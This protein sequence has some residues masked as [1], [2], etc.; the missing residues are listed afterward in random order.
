MTDSDGQQSPRIQDAGH[1]DAYYDLGHLH[2]PVTTAYPAAQTW[3]DRGLVWCYGFNHEE[4]AKCFERVIATDRACAIGH[5]GLAYALGPNYNKP[6]ELFGRRERQTTAE[7]TNHAVEQALALALA[8]DASP[9]E[10]ALIDAL[11]HRYPTDQAPGKPEACIWNAAYADAMSAVAARFPD[12]LDVAALYADALMNL[13]PWNLWDIRTGV[14]ARGARTLEAKRVLDR[15]LAQD[16]G[17]RHPGVLHMY[18]HLMEMSQ[19][20]EAAMPAADKLRGLVPDAGHLN[21]MPSH[22]DIL[23]G[24]YARAVDANSDAVRADIKF[25]EREGP[26]N[27]YTLYRS[28]DY[29]F[30][31]YAALFSG[32]SRIALE[33]VDMLEASISEELLRVESPPMADWLEAFLAMRVHALVRFGR[34]RDVL[35]IRLPEDRDLYCVTTALVY[36]ARGMAL[37]AM[38]RVDEAVAQRQL[39]RGAVPR[40]KPSRTL[41]NNKCVDIL[42]VAEAM[43]DG[44]VEYRRCNFDAAFHHLRESIRRYDKLPFDEPWG[45]MQPARHAYGALLLEQGHVKEALGVYRADLGLDE[46]L[47]RVHRHPNNVWALHGYHECLLR[48]G[49]T[50]EAKRVHPQLQAALA[51]ADVPISSSCYCRTVLPKM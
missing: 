40:V 3:F 4:A 49:E 12:D 50:E 23:V 27:F 47:P 11:R 24:D 29:H 36:Y 10:G 41:F 44:E 15:A 31:L 30:R 32:Q 42:C 35:A 18:I 20:P 37:A 19:T 46:S 16:G 5:W 1:D 9:V 51:R 34:W 48:L 33:T 21:H 22:L 7:R 14:P 38:G 26:L 43:L 6:W 2:R 45:W 39:F 17:D 13:T 8:G 28:H 25:L